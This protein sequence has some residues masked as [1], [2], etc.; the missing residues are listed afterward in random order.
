MSGF[1]TNFSVYF[2][3]P[4][5]TEASRH[6]LKDGYITSDIGGSSLGS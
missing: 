3:F 1:V 6:S 5:C 2:L 4:N